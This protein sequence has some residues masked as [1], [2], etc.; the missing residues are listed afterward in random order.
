MAS[1]SAEVVPIV[2][3]A[4]RDR[5][6]VLERIGCE[7]R[8]TVTQPAAPVSYRECRYPKTVE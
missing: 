7:R 6:R 8:W 4:A 2:E 5:G 3:P 1:G